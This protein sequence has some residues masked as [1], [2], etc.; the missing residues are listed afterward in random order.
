[1]EYFSI[2]NLKKE[3]FS[4]S[5]DPDF[6][7]HS[8]QHL[9]CLQKL[10]LSLRLRRG[11]NVI[12]GDVGT[13]KTTMC[14]QIIRRFATKEDIDTHL[15]LDPHFLN[16]SEFLTTVT[17]MLLGKK[18]PVGSNEWQLKE[19]IK[20]HLFQR[21]VDQNKTTVLII[22]EGQKI[23]A[24]CLEILR[25]FLN[26]ETN[27]YKLLQIIIFAQREFENTVRKYPN[28][29]DR[30]N[31][32]H[33]L[34]PLNYRDTRLMIKFR[35]EKSRNTRKKLNLFTLPALWTVYRISGG[36]PRRIINLCHQCILSMIIQNRSKVS[37][38]L[39]R[40]CANRVFTD[41][42]YRWKKISAATI[43]AVAAAAILLL[44]LPSSRLGILKSWIVKN[45]PT[46][47]EQKSNQ[48]Q[49]KV[50]KPKP[51]AQAVKA[52]LAPTEFHRQPTAN[53]P[54]VRPEIEVEPPKKTEEKAPIVA[55]IAPPL[56]NVEPAIKTEPKYSDILGTLILQR[57]DTL[58]L[59][60]QQIYGN[61]NSK[62]FK[63]FILANPDIED[64]DRVEV[65]RTV[66]LPAIPADVK[67][68][69]TSV[70]W[71]IVAETDSLQDAYNI[72]RMQ[73]DNS[74]PL[75]L[76]PF[77]NPGDGTKFAVVVKKLF[78][79]ERLAQEQLT[80][81]PDEL[82]SNGIKISMYDENNVYF[83]DPYFGRQP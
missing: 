49:N 3:P 59:I 30:I 39:V 17:K 46:L 62:Y 76:I 18:P 6:F 61:F 20:Q 8:R 31:L 25:E 44:L 75:R 11:L 83:A 33:L 73:S 69:D 65:G 45:P 56:P 10:E 41:E 77:W 27:D 52:Q 24:F 5:P 74:L 2:L 14:R 79:D 23:P 71:V 22:D 70:W 9:D 63:T 32:Y 36:Y 35:L 7:F 40:T 82:S 19:Y 28:F 78:K 55:T 67:P 16:A 12:I 72:L 13:G 34:K 48:E 53:P 58:S 29:A 81:L 43:S 57:N 47:S 26:Y 21:G 1:M 37:Y 51:A 38:F 50:L 42:S 64:P 80:K 66:S 54:P 60:I 4:N 68:W 15:I